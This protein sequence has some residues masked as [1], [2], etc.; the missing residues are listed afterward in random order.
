MMPAMT[1][2]V[3]LSGPKLREAASF[4]EITGGLSMT[5]GASANGGIALR[6]QSTRFVA[7][8]AGSLGIARIP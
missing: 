2:F 7:A 5:P 8:V 1:L 6:L 3:A 4:N